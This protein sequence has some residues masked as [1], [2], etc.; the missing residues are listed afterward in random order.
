MASVTMHLGEK[1]EYGDIAVKS[2]GICYHLLGKD[3]MDWNH[4]WKIHN[5][6]HHAMNV[7]VSIEPH[8]RS[9]GLS[10]F[11]TV[12]AQG[13]LFVIHEATTASLHVDGN[14]QALATAEP[15]TDIADVVQL[16]KEGFMDEGAEHYY[17]SY[18]IDIDFDGHG[19]SFHRS[20]SKGW[21]FLSFSGSRA[22]AV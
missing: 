1:T 8:L 11:C 16:L 12:P 9:K 17:G 7:H 15:V 6:H 5:P 20:A 19:F 21:Y 4:I 14:G 22:F 2:L 18:A 13:S 3:D 10:C